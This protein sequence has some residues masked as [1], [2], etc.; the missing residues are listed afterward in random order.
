MN[1][2][3]TFKP[4]LNKKTIDLAAKKGGK[5][6]DVYSRLTSSVDRLDVGRHAFEEPTFVPQINPISDELDNRVK[7]TETGKERW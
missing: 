2:C 1:E 3:E 7:V 4:A 6:G 5:R